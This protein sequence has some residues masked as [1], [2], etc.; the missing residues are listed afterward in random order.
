MG[1]GL[2]WFFSWNYCNMFL[3]WLGRILIYIINNS[4]GTIFIPSI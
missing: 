3:Y 2:R 4:I 1:G